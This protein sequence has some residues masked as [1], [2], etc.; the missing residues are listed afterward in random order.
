MKFNEWLADIEAQK[1]DYKMDEKKVEKS[2]RYT[3]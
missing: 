2:D 3:H 1:Q